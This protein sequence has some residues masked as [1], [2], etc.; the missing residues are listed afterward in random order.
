MFLFKV[1][2]C[3]AILTPLCMGQID[4]SLF[5]NYLENSLSDEEILMKIN[6]KL[7][8]MNGY[9]LVDFSGED[10]P[11]D[12]HQEI[13]KQRRYINQVISKREFKRCKQTVVETNTMGQTYFEIICHEMDRA[14]TNHGYIINEHCHNVTKNFKFKVS[15]GGCEMKPISIKMGCATV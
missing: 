12:Y 15:R 10:Y 11:E 8:D 6:E 4:R 2:L 3:G 14:G 9:Q 7:F 13:E 1:F 5:D